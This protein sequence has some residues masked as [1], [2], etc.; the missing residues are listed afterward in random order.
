MLRRRSLWVAL[1]ATAA[2]ALGSVG[3][4]ASLAHSSG[5]PIGHSALAAPAA[6]TPLAVTLETLKP[7]VLPTRGKIRVVGT[8]TN[9]DAVTWR[10]VNVYSFISAAPLVNRKQVARAARTPADSAVGERITAADNYDSIEAIEPGE[11][12]QFSFT[13]ERAAL[14]DA[15]SAQGGAPG[16]PGVYWF[17]VHA[18]GDG[19]QGRDLIADGRA[20]TFLP[21]VPPRREGVE[22]LAI[23]IPLRSQ[24]AYAEDG[25]LIDLARWQ[26]LL[27]PGGRLRSL[28]ELASSAGE[29]TLTWVLDPALIDAVRQLAA[30]NPP[31]SLAANLEPPAPGEDA[32]ASA[33]SDSA[34]A[35]PSAGAS[36]SGEATPG[37]PTES[38]DPQIQDDPTQVALDDALDEE[39]LAAA[40]AARDWLA[41]L[42]AAM[43]TGDEVLALPYG[44]I[45]VSAAASHGSPAYTL[46]TSRSAERLVGFDLVPAPAVAAP[47]GYLT[48]QA[49]RGLDTEV[50]ALVTDQAFADPPTVADFAGHRLV[51]TSSGAASG[52]PGPGD[53]QGN[54]AMRQ[55]ILAEAAVRFLKSSREPLVVLLPH[56]WV[57]AETS[58]FFTGL[59]PTWLRMRSVTQA[60]GALTATPVAEDEPSYP[61]RQAQAE[62]PRANFA[63]ADALR[64][65]GETLDRF[66]TL[67][68]V[69]GQT[70]SDQALATTSYSARARP[71]LARVA[72]DRS[73]AWIEQ[74][75]AQV[76]VSAPQ[77]VTL[78][79]IHGSFPVTLSNNLDEPVTVSLAATADSGLTMTAPTTIDIAAEGTATV[80]LE[81][82]TEAGGIHDVTLMV[83]DSEGTQ[84][85]GSD[86]LSIRSARVSNIIWLFMAAGLVLLFSTI[87]FRLVR[88][89]RTGRR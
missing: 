66:L 60:T 29:R 19:G 40:T 31:R 14:D 82:D 56:D 35:E 88:R 49:I 36:G 27:S 34:S 58:T 81:V 62:L 52:G 21:L 84:L 20:R 78:S 79:S 89:L 7:S 63:A 2:M 6:D 16:A 45:D 70:V 68:D 33:G 37:S 43:D 67:N 86:R 47:S 75:L 22:N 54:L 57:P 28:V 51:V 38:S 61:E 24:I 74:R 69:V 39:T 8:V 13:V 73:R 77:T 53:P 25:S 44:D 3:A 4:G 72:T 30:G 87:G 76:E 83:T 46:A 42:R 80:L 17:G 1:A 23:V 64:R 71:E 41:R 10:N 59:E 32:T 48:T 9:T 65:A 26:T 55:R 12:K 11:S 5:R 50:T 15:V 18:L 85:G